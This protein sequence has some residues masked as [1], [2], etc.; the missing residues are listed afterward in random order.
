MT[1]EPQQLTTP[2]FADESGTRA[3]VLQWLARGICACFVLVSGAVALTLAT[4]VPLPGLGGLVAPR[5]DTSAPPTTAPRVAAEDRAD[6][7]A[8]AMLDNAFAARAADDSARSRTVVRPALDPAAPRDVSS[9]VSTGTRPE[10]LSPAPRPTPQA[11][12]PAPAPA[13]THPAP[14]ADKADPHATTKS[15][16]AQAGN[17]SPSP[18]ATDPS[19][20]PRGQARGLD[21]EP[22]PG[23]TR[24]SE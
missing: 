22:A 2:V 24:G 5:T 3:A 19:P 9:S 18:R 16:N 14:A 20:S 23:Q 15:E 17:T 4:D 1:V 10:V 7:L 12:A 8:T 13:P 21:D 11:A 6:A